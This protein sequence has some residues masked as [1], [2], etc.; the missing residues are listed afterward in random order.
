MDVQ[1][2]GVQDEIGLAAKLGEQSALGGDA[3]DQRVALTQRM[4]DGGRSR[5]G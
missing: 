5:T 1:V 3:V 4:R 2:G